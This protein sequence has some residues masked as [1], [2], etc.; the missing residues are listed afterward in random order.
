MAESAR[1]ARRRQNS[2]EL[3]SM[4]FRNFDPA[5]KAFIQFIYAMY[6][7]M[8]YI[9]PFRR[10]GRPMDVIISPG[11]DSSGGG[12]GSDVGTR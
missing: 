6:S 7:E 10:N 3:N 9:L 1:R 11:G 2:D 12:D 4:R 5:A 8:I